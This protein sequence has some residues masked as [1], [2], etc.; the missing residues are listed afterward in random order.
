MRNKIIKNLGLKILALVTAIVLWLIVVNI[1]DPVISTTF[2]EVPVEIVNANLLSNDGKVYQVLEGT[3]KISITVA[4]KRSILDYLNNSN[5]RAT[6]DIEEL[7]PTDGT[8]RIRVEANRYNNQIDSIKPKTEYLK[9]EIENR[10][11]A[12]F[13]I[14][15]VVLGKPTDGYVVGDV[16]MNQNIVIVSGPESLVSKIDKV[17]TEVSVEGM[18]SDVSTNMKLKYYDINGQLLD[19]SRL[20]SNISSV[21]LDVEILETKEVPIVVKVSGTPME[22]YG[23]NGEAVV[24]P[25]TVVIAGRSTALNGVDSIQ[26]SG[27][28]VNVDDLN[29]N[30]NVAVKIKDLLPDGIVLADDKDDG[31]VVISVQI[32]T[33]ITRKVGVPK[34]QITINDIPQGYVAEFVT[35]EDLLD[36]EIMG[37]E[38]AIGNL[39]ISLVTGEC[40]VKTY[41]QD[42]KIT[43]LEKGILVIPVTFNI[44][45][46]ITQKTPV[47]VSVKFRKSA[48]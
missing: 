3:D 42:N 8:I 5:L 43:D 22:G 2:S 26:I 25:A 10:K 46:G 30:L 18:S 36:L 24:E 27:E 14:D 15:A 33:L 7:N 39:D 21:D 34:G 1:S 4:A 23:I 9:L 32:E 41:M 16:G 38:E 12:Q 47:T 48:E 45:D 13:P 37:L 6:A 20:N 31:K 28:K 29:E 11:N 35:D 44:P 17:K 40:N 19:H